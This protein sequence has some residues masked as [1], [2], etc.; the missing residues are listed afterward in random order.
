MTTVALA[1][2][3]HGNVRWASARIADVA[4]RQVGL[5]LHLGDFGIWPGESGEQYML[6]VE[7]GLR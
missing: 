7:R 2:D 6:D 5:I 4:V 1:G 3:W